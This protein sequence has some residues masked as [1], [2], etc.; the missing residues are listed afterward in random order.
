M[1]R[2]TVKGRPC[3]IQASS[4]T[5]QAWMA[6][7]ATAAAAACDL[8]FIT[9]DLKIEIVFFYNTL[10]DFDTDNISKPICDA[11]NGLVYRDDHQLCKRTSS[12]KDINGSY[13]IRGAAPAL[14]LA[15]AEGDDFVYI[16]VDQLTAD[17]AQR[18]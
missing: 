6:K 12:R 4:A 13:R 9:N 5:R 18:L 16:E 11:L 15:I 17:E 14:A 10:P 2:F 3:S 1:I 7:I 8:A